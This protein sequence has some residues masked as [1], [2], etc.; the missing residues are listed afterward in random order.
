M[1]ATTEQHPKT[2]FRS[3]AQVEPSE[4]VSVNSEFITGVNIQKVESKFAVRNVTELMVDDGQ[5]SRQRSEYA[6]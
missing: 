3:D 2:A 5:Q 4:E 6:V 1:V